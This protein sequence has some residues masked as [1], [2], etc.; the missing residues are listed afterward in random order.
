MYDF[1]GMRVIVDSNAVETKFLFPEKTRSKRLHKKLI[2]KFGKQKEQIP[3]A[4]KLGNDL[5]VHPEVYDRLKKESI[6]GK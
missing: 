1:Y 3:S 5:Y 4:W 2:K 6:V